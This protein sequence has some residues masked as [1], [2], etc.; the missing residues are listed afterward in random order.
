MKTNSQICDVFSTRNF[1]DSMFV[2]Q[3]VLPDR[4]RTKHETSSFWEPIK[5][6]TSCKQDFNLDQSYTSTNENPF[7]STAYGK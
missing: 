4:C 1:S 5:G 2:R 3:D 7:Q 6:W